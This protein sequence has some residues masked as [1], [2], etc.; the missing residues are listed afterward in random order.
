MPGRTGT[1][2]LE[3]RTLNLAPS[4]NDQTARSVANAALV[5][6]A[7][8]TSY[9]VLR[10]PRLRGMVFAALKTVLTTT[11]SAYL[12]TEVQQAW[13]ESGRRARA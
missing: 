2:D 13:V 3:R 10:Q 6:A 4:M 9:Y 12:F 5:A 1:L 7:L 11:V 8:I